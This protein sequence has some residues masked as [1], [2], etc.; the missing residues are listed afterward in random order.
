MDSHA[1]HLL[2]ILWDYTAGAWSYFY[3]VLWLNCLYNQYS[4]AMDLWPHRKDDKE[5]NDSLNLLPQDALKI[6]SSPK[7]VTLLPPMAILPVYSCPKAGSKHLRTKEC[8]LK[9]IQFG[10]ISHQKA[11]LF[12]FKG[13][14]SSMIRAYAHCVKVG[15]CQHC[16]G[17]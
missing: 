6:P 4:E 15:A 12:W 17:I 16:H 10:L 11:S 5:G 13:L 7:S 1:S 14:S 9:S 3:I 8:F 2:V